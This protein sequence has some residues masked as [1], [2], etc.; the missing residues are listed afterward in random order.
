MAVV[1]TLGV[2]G[3]P[4]VPWSSFARGIGGSRGYL[5]QFTVLGLSATPKTSWGSTSGRTP[6]SGARTYVGQFTTLGVTAIPRTPW[7][8]FLG[9]N[10]TGPAFETDIPGKIVFLQ[11]QGP[12]ILQPSSVGNTVVDVPTL[13]ILPATLAPLIV[14]DQDTIAVVPTSALTLAPLMPDVIQQDFLPV[15]PPVINMTLT[16]LMP[17]ITQLA[18]PL[19]WN[20]SEPGQTG[21][22]RVVPKAAGGWS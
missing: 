7:G 5:G 8:N 19:D 15:F 14:A 16:P 10:D 17:T 2:G 21:I 20:P 18:N 4:R 6:Q 1:S 13:S 22:W 9:R 11:T 3:T 12:T